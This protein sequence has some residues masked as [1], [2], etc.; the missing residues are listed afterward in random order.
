[1]RIALYLLLSLGLFSGCDRR[2]PEQKLDESLTALMRPAT[3]DE[4]VNE[5]TVALAAE[6]YVRAVDGVTH[7][8]G[9]LVMPVEN[10]YSANTLARRAAFTYFLERL[11]AGIPDAMRES[12]IS[13]IPFGLGV[14]GFW[15]WRAQSMEAVRTYLSDRDRLVAA[16]VH[17]KPTALPYIERAKNREAIR[18]H[19]RDVVIPTFT[20]DVS[21]NLLALHVENGRLS[22]VLNGD[23]DDARSSDEAAARFMAW[24]EQR[25]RFETQAHAEGFSDAYLL[26]WR[27]RRYAEGGDDL[28]LAW[29]VI[30]EDFYGSMTWSLAEELWQESV[31]DAQDAAAKMREEGTLK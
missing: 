28:V 7:E 24:S 9:A 3:F 14:D 18:I 6:R 26:Q 11:F 30:V 10:V 8:H 16:Y 13:G 21:A 17:L 29:R 1:M 2:S 23:S 31:K 27:L 22:E 5:Q 4:L 15:D 25:A 12:P 20:Q 19:L